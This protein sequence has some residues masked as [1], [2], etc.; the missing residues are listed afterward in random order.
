LD[1]LLD[2]E[3]LTETFLTEDLTAQVTRLC[4]TLGLKGFEILAVLPNGPT[5][6]PDPQSSA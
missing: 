6:P 3:E 2:I 5:H 1:D 4:N